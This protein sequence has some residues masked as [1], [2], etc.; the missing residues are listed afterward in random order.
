MMRF[1]RGTFFRI[2]G[3]GYNDFEAFD[4]GTLNQSLG[5]HAT[6]TAGMNFGN[7]VIFHRD[8]VL[9]PPRDLYLPSDNFERADGALG[10]NWEYPAQSP[11]PNRPQ[12]QSHHVIQGAINVDCCAFWDGD[13]LTWEVDQFR[14]E[15]IVGQFAQI[16]IADPLPHAGGSGNYVGVVLRCDKVS[17]SKFYLGVLFWNGASVDCRLYYWNGTSVFVAI[18]L[19]NAV[20]TWV[21]GDVL[22]CEVTGQGVSGSPLRLKMLHNDTTIFNV[23]L[24]GA[25][26]KAGGGS[27]APGPGIAIHGFDAS[28]WIDNWSAGELRQPPDHLFFRENWNSHDDGPLGQP[29]SFPFPSPAPRP[30]VVSHQVVA[31]GLDAYSAAYYNQTGFN[32]SD[33]YAQVQ[34]AT[35]PTLANEKL[36]IILRAGGGVDALY[37]GL[38]SSSTD[39]GIWFYWNDGSH[40]PGQ[41]VWT[42]RVQRTSYPPISAGGTLRCEVKGSVTPVFNMYW[43]GD[44]VLTY[45]FNNSPSPDVRV[46]GFPGFVMFDPTGGTVLLLDNWEGGRL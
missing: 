45:T 25:A 6:L 14:P 7:S 19:P 43:N 16:V 2:G 20:L 21:P 8:Y 18:G 36:G 1:L 26:V 3:I 44:L 24:T 28:V 5:L 32:A 13:G 4:P 31:G 37:A 41:G 33:Q 38:I 29:W 27:N 15:T 12:I 34:I 23:T 40:P 10:T 17:G 9:P 42:R 30:R 46:G 39:L 11:A 22:R 35:M